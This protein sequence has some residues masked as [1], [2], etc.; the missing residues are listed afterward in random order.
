[1][2]GYVWV[3]NRGG[4]CFIDRQ[5]FWSRDAAEKAL[6]TWMTLQYEDIERHD[7]GNYYEHGEYVQAYV[8]EIEIPE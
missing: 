1:M 5:V 6:Y 3:D 4:D 2:I 7:D 8:K